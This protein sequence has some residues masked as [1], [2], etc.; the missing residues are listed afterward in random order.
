[1]AQDKDKDKPLR[2]YIDTSSQ[3]SATE[4]AGRAGR[5]QRVGGGAGGEATATSQDAFRSTSEQQSD[6]GWR[7]S[8]TTTEREGTAATQGQE[9]GAQYGRFYGSA[10]RRLSQQRQRS[11]YSPSEEQPGWGSQWGRERSRGGQSAYRG[12][13]EEFGRGGLRPAGYGTQAYPARRP[14]GAQPGWGEAG[15]FRGEGYGEEGYERQRGYGRPRGREEGSYGRPGEFEEGRGSYEPPVSRRYEEPRT[16]GFYDEPRGEGTYGESQAAY[17]GEH[18][19]YGRWEPAYGRGAGAG[20]YEGGLHER[21]E[22]QTYGRT[23]EGYGGSEPAYRRG[24]GREGYWRRDPGNLGFTGGEEYAQAERGGGRGYGWERTRFQEGRRTRWQREALTAREIM[25]R[26]VKAVTKQS[27]LKNVA[28]VMKDENCGIV[29]V[30]DEQ[31]KLL[32]V[33][34]DRDIVIRA[35]AEDKT[36]SELKVE[37][38]MTDDVEAVTPDEELKDVIELMGNKQIRRIPV[39]DKD[40]RLCGIISMGDIAN[41]ADYD[42]DLQE[43]LEKVSAKRSFWGGLRS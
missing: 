17:R 40:D 26:E 7:A 24:E 27:T 31:H 41:R 34:T 22:V 42:E 14:Y 3:T 38:I 11:A 8:S 9:S 30:V 43:T 18:Q 21:A 29:P 6:K 1:M 5:A 13:T 12:E 28:E 37:D 4:T 36:V 20:S 33:V 16:G 35:L 2:D 23:R 39:V 25:T 10:Q 19:G 15:Y 32:G